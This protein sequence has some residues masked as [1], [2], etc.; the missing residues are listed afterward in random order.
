MFELIFHWCKFS[1]R[2]HGVPPT[3]TYTSESVSELTLSKL[4][5]LNPLKIKNVSFSTEGN[6]FVNDGACQMCAQCGLAL[7]VPEKVCTM[8]VWAPTAPDGQGLSLSLSLSLCLSLS[9]SLC[10]GSYPWCL[11]NS[12][13]GSGYR[14]CAM[15]GQIVL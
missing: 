7:L 1:C 3:Y 12:S 8:Q 10:P 5:L 9:L 15:N 4:T 13:D 2:Q 11:R 6:N 14:L